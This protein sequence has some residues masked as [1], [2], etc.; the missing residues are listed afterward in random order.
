M[1]H[2]LDDAYAELPSVDLNTLPGTTIQPSTHHCILDS[3]MA[4][5]R[6]ESQLLL[7][8]L[9]SSDGYVCVFCFKTVVIFYVDEIDVCGSILPIIQRLLPDI[10]VS[11][12]WPDNAQI[13]ITVLLG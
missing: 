6:R 9:L 1:Q 13:D 12:Y 5:I 4:M 7:K 8:Y 11:R 2:V 3:R 10:Q